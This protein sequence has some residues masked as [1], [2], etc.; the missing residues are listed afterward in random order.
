MGTLLVSLHIIVSAVLVLA[1]LLQ[2]GKG[3]S[4]VGALGGTGAAGAMLGSRGA[5][6]MLSKITTA[7]AILFL[8]SCVG[9]T[10]VVRGG[11]GAPD[12]KSAA[13]KSAQSRLTPLKPPAAPA[14][15]PQQAAP[16]AAQPQP[17]Q[18]EG[19]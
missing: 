5:A 16:A 18:T 3:G 11:R 6:T 10:F 4:L 1:I 19:R 17:T 13:E 15:T 8:V 14:Q 12:V 2:S 7:A 9:L